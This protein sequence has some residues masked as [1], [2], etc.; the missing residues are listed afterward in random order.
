MQEREEETQYKTPVLGD[1]PVMGWLFKQKSH[2]KQ[3]T[4][5]IV[6]LTPHIIKEADDLKKI[7]DEKKKDFEEKSGRVVE[8]ELI[9]QFKREVPEEKINEII[10]SR[11]ARIIK[12]FDKIRV[13]HIRLKAGVRIKDAEREFASLSEVEYAEPNYK[14]K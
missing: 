10:A 9:V 1:I 5:L 6:F 12:Q 2:T 7:T 3:K 4:N 11:G 13:Y 14:I 8:G